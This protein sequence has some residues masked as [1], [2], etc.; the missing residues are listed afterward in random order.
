MSFSEILNIHAEKFHTLICLPLERAY[1][2]TSM[3]LFFHRCNGQMSTFACKI[4]DDFCC[5]SYLHSEISKHFLPEKYPHFC[6][7]H[8]SDSL[9]SNC[10]FPH[11]NRICGHLLVGSSKRAQEAVDTGVGFKEKN[12]TTFC[13]CL[14]AS[15]KSTWKPCWTCAL[16][17]AAKWRRKEH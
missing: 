16:Y 12:K 2:S 8:R 3:Q 4:L 17:A 6:G 14:H 9:P 5:Y 13:S 1:W 10:W 11:S 7:S 15:S